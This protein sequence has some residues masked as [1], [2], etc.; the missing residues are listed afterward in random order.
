VRVII[1]ELPEP[2]SNTEI[3]LAA[4]LQRL[5]ILLMLAHEKQAAVEEDDPNTI[6]LLS[7]ERLTI[8]R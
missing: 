6:E 7:G 5:E 2:T 1:T 3:Y 4:I 8:V